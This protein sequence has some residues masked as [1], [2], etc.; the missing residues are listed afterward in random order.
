MEVNAS[1]GRISFPEFGR[2]KRDMPTEA[3]AAVMIDMNT[4]MGI[5]EGK[6]GP[7]VVEAS[8][9]LEGKRVDERFVFDM[10]VL[11]PN[12]EIKVDVDANTGDILAPGWDKPS[13]GDIPATLPSYGDDRYDGDRYGDDRD[14]RLEDFF[15][16]DRDDDRR[17]R[18]RWD[19]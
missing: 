9:D 14:D 8:L 4:A 1:T 3:E 10:E 11:K 15:E 2:I 19:D 16:R 18:N 5:A 6:T 13:L 17:G 12:Y 7:C